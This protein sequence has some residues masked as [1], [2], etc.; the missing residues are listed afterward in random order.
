[1]K[2]IEQRFFRRQMLMKELPRGIVIRRR[3]DEVVARENPARVSIGHKH[4]MPPGVEQDGVRRF[5]ANSLEGQKL[6]AC[7]FHRLSKERVERTAMRLTDPLGD[8]V[9]RPRL[10]A[11]KACGANQR[12]QF[13]QRK[14]DACARAR[15]RPPAE[16]S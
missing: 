16:G 6:G 10:L 8:I 5:R 12:F 4:R 9:Q 11:V 7:Q 15:E 3:G 1:M 14:F 13:L 2:F